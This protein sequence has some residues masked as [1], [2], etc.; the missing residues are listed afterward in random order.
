VLRSADELLAPALEETLVK[1]QLA[2]ADAA[3][4]KLARRY[5]E[6]LD[7]GAELADHVERAWEELDPEDQKGRRRLA[8][9]EAKLVGRAALADLGPKLLATLQAL[10]AT[11]AARARRKGTG[12]GDA[13]PN[14]L[15]QLRATRRA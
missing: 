5:A 15:Q 8:M 6:T 10:G 11:P 7:A 3:L 14:R 9:I 13:G 12:G 4:V 2:D 1:L